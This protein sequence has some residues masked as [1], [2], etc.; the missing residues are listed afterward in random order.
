MPGPRGSAEQRAEKSAGARGGLNDVSCLC[1]TG[2][3]EIVKRRNETAD[4][5]RM[6]TSQ[7]QCCFPTMDPIE[8]ALEGL[9]AGG[10]EA[11]GAIFTP[12]SQDSER[13][14]CDVLILY[15]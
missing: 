3:R 6:R 1:R 9:K 10:V 15:L 14:A 4:R 7:Q 8:E 12:H 11:R 5:Y 13:H 2:I